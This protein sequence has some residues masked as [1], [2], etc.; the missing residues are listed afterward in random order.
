MGI[1]IEDTTNIEDLLVGEGSFRDLEELPDDSQHCCRVSVI[2]GSKT[3]S[4]FF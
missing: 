3:G 4:I 2:P 1:N